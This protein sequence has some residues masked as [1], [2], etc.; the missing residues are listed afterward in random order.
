MELL[1]DRDISN[2][3]VSWFQ[4]SD[5]VS[6]FVEDC[7]SWRVLKSRYV[8]YGEFKGCPDEIITM[9]SNLK[10]NSKSRINMLAGLFYILFL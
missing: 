3:H 10:K 4:C 7:L 1:Y 5:L 6:S 8:I 2:W 9:A